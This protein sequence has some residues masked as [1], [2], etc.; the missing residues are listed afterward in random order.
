MPGDTALKVPLGTT[1]PATVLVTDCSGV[2]VHE[3]DEV[4]AYRL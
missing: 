2:P 4:P 1:P 3:V